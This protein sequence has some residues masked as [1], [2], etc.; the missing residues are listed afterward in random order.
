MI[1][2]THVLPLGLCF[3]I[4][5]V[6]SWAQLYQLEAVGPQAWTSRGLSDSGAARS[7]WS[8]LPNMPT[9]VSRHSTPPSPWGETEREAGNTALPAVGA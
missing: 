8:L 7:P 9:G 4:Y 2:D 3:L 6:S 5:K 1:L